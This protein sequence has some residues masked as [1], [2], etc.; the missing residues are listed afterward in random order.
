V[1]R[2][3][4]V[5]THLD[6]FSRAGYVWLAVACCW[7]TCI[8]WW[9][10]CCVHLVSDHQ[11]VAGECWLVIVPQL[12]VDS[13]MLITVMICVRVVYPMKSFSF[14]AGVRICF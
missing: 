5:K 11:L 13:H 1:G 6:N 4:L 12:S 8:V 9:L 10:M 2:C 3:L 14:C 7:V